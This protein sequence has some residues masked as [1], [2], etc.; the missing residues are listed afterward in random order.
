MINMRD[1]IT[2]KHKH[3]L[4]KDECGD[5]F[6]L[7]KDCE[8]YVYSNDVLGVTCFSNG[9]KIYR[10]LRAEIKDFFITDDWLYLF[11]VDR[12]KLVHIL[13]TLPT[14]KIRINKHSRARME[15]ERRL[16]HK[17]INYNPKLKEE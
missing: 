5:D 13:A 3:L 17:I 2:E 11:R 6:I 7:T 12:A 4:Y 9:K 15:L 16:A 10:L 8:I 14:T 1:I